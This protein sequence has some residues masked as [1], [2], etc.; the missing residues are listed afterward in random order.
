MGD[1]LIKTNKE[2][3]NKV[4]RELNKWRAEKLDKDGYVTQKEFSDKLRELL[5]FKE[6]K[7]W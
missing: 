1:V 5:G 6:E 7:E 3:L 4:A 2:T